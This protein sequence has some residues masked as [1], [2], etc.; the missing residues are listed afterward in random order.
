[1]R[2]H[3]LLRYDFTTLLPYYFTA[4]Q[5]SYFPTFLTTSLLTSSE[6]R[7]YFPTFRTTSLLTNSEARVKAA[8][9]PDEPARPMPN[10][11]TQWAAK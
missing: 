11:S 1:M 8:T 3:S 10:L 6:L 2:L 9:L 5:R 4:V 7:S